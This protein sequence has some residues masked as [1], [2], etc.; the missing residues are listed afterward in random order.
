M[1]KLEDTNTLTSSSHIRISDSYITLHENENV[2]CLEMDM[3]GNGTLRRY[4]NNPDF[5]YFYKPDISNKMIVLN[6]VGDHLPSD[7]FYYTGHVSISNIHFYDRRLNTRQGYSYRTYT[8]NKLGTNTNVSNLDSTLIQKDYKSKTKTIRNNR[9]KLYPQIHTQRYKAKLLD[10]IKE[11][12]EL[13]IKNILTTRDLIKIETARTQI[14]KTQDTK[15]KKSYLN[16][17]KT[18]VLKGGKY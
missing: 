4:S 15:L 2:Y 6:I 17:I 5:M 10:D 8:N 12:R 7:L 9:L 1:I 11:L 13:K 16:R 3:V 18:T 14:Q